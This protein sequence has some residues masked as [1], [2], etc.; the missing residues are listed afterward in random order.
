[1]EYSDLE[2][3]IE[4]V[5]NEV[6]QLHKKTNCIDVWQAENGQKISNILVCIGE[7]KEAIKNVNVVELREA[8][9]QLK[10]K[11]AKRWEGFVMAL[12]G[13]GAALLMGYLISIIK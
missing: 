5:E 4:I 6:K 1:M 2:R 11:P 13:S 8:V 3:R 10:N 9:D 7:L 12:I